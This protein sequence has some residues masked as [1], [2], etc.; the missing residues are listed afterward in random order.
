MGGSFGAGFLGTCVVD[1]YG[2]F[3]G[4][5]MGGAAGVTNGFITGTGNSLIDN[6]NIGES[7]LSGMDAAWKQG[8]GGATIGG[9][10][11]GIVAAAKDRNFWTGT[12]NKSY[13][14]KLTSE[15]LNINIA[16]QR[17]QVNTEGMRNKIN[18]FYTDS[19]FCFDG[20]S[21]VWYDNY[22]N[23][24]QRIRYSWDA[25][26]GVDG[27]NS[28]PNG[29]YKG[30]NLR[31]RTN[32]SMVRDG[33]GFSI[34]LN[35]MWDPKLGRLRTLLR[36]HPDGNINGF[37][38]LNDGSTGCISIQSYASDLNRFF[39]YLEKYLFYNGHINI[40]VFIP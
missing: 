37:W 3:A 7:L 33:I 40:N 8:L 5:S 13:T 29:L 14:P 27:E 21:I 9:L 38:W 32:P 25:T 17:A 31:V 28:L 30:T 23:G 26:S 20:E 36:I 24:A 39:N 10:S 19:E 11:G 35:D 2:F 34:D 16:E 22:S 15:R 4:A 12:P 1:G 18:P 6:K